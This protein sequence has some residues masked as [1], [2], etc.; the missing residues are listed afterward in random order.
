LKEANETEY[1][2]NILKDTNYIEENLFMSL[3][4]DCNELIRLLIA[5]VK[6]AKINNAKS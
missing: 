4:N 3:I 6:T 2:I 5:S 1:W